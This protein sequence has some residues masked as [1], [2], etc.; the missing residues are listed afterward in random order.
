M[1]VGCAVHVYLVFDP[2]ENYH[3]YVPPCSTRPAEHG[4]NRAHP[5]GAYRGAVE[6]GLL[7]SNEFNPVY[8][9]LTASWI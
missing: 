9:S 8:Q 7:Y 6:R 4:T 5:W 3:D 2:R 1:Q